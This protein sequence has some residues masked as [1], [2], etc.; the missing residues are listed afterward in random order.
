MIYTKEKAVLDMGRMAWLKQRCAT[1]KPGKIVVKVTRD[2]NLRCSYC[3]TKGGEE[4]LHISLDIVESFFD[5]LAEDNPNKIDCTFHGGEPLLK[6]NLLKDIVNTLNKKYYAPRLS[7]NIQTNATLIN[8]DWIEFFKENGITSIGVSLDGVEEVHD[9]YRKNA[10]GKGSFKDVVKGLKILQDAGISGGIICVITNENVNQMVEF[11]Q[12]CKENNIKGVSYNPAFQNGYAEGNY[13]IAPKISDYWEQSKKLIDWLVE[14]NR[15]CSPE[16][17]MYEREIE[18]I[19][20]NIISPSNKVYMCNST[21]CGAGTRHLG[22][23]VNGDVEVCDT[24]YGHKD[25]ILGNIQKDKLDDIIKNP[26]IEKFSNRSQEK[27][28]NC[29]SCN[30]KQWCSSGCP[31]GNIIHYG[32]DGINKSSYNCGFFKKIIPYLK[33][34]FDSGEIDPE[35]LCQYIPDINKTVSNNKKEGMIG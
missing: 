5:Q 24:L 32:P 34:K 1:P 26:I 16:D 15:Q 7:Y 10:A 17:R 9:K 23:D 33:E 6:P 25:Y 35:L 27:L 13:G 30:L 2:C 28:S 12:W 18:S 11:I 19:T 4:K 31:A 8:S 29:K 21:P 3:Y 14:N 22:L 20:R